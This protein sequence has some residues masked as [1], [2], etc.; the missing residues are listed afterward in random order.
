MA[1]P[2]RSFKGAQ[3]NPKALPGT[4]QL[5]RP[6][7]LSTLHHHPLYHPHLL[8]IIISVISHQKSEKT[9]LLIP[10]CLKPTYEHRSLVFLGSQSPHL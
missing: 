9:C 10:A 7:L 1:P 5:L 6:A 4:L 2:E 8:N 3:M